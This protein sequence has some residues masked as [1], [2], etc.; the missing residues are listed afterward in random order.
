MAPQFD[1]EL[2]LAYLHSLARTGKHAQALLGLS[3][4][5]QRK[6]L[7]KI[8]NA[9][10]TG[11]IV[12]SKRDI[13][14]L[15]K[16]KTF[17][18]RIAASNQSASKFARNTPAVCLLVRIFLSKNENYAK[19]GLSPPGR[20]GKDQ[21]PAAES[22]EGGRQKK[23]KCPSDGAEKS[24][25][26]RKMVQPPSSSSSSSSSGTDLTSSEEGEQEEEEKGKEPHRRDEGGEEPEEN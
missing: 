8:C 3:S 1:D 10:L 24:K 9:I 19:V 21:T 11:Q 14:K 12:T 25:K 7:R 4:P 2:M 13:E 15:R 5:K 22:S 23:H 6:V 20:M 17:L 18:R 16:S 26:R